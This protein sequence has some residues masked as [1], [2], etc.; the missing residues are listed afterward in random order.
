MFVG[1]I[2]LLLLL[3]WPACTVARSHYEVLEVPKDADAKSIKQ[4]YR[5]MALKWHPDKNPDDET[6]EQRFREVAEA[7]EVLSDPERRKNYDT[8]G[9]EDGG[10]RRGG[11]GGFGGFGGFNFKDPNDLFNDFFG[12][13]DPFADFSSFF[14]MD[15]ETVE[16]NEDVLPQALKTF[17]SAIGA[18]KIVEPRIAEICGKWRGKEEKLV[19]SLEKKYPQHSGAVAALKKD[20]GLTKDNSR[21]G[22]GFGGFDF[23]KGDGRFGSLSGFDFGKFGSSGSSFSTS[24]TSSFS[25]SSGGKTVRTETVIKDGKRVSKTVESDGTNTRATLEES[26]GKNVRRKTGTKRHEQLPSDDL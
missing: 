17:Y 25:S 22:G 12:G 21:S 20:L 26:D 13:K 6:A 14:D 5:K 24:F 10:P 16:M 9:A 18:D 3:C 23:G 2:A 7:Y 1:R 19:R 11:G 8:F 4:A 15:E